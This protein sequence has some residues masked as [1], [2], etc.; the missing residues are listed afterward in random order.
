MGRGRGVLPSAR[1]ARPGTILTG[2]VDQITAPAVGGGRGAAAGSGGAL[3]EAQRAAAG[4]RQA[5][6]EVQRRVAAGW[7]RAAEA[8]QQRTAAVCG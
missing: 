1:A 6:T 8:A 4:G 5:A 3:A 7:R 2:P